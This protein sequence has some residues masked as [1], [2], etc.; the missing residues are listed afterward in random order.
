MTHHHFWVRAATF[1][2]ALQIVL[3]SVVMRPGPVAAQD[4]ARDCAG[5]AE[6][7][8][9]VAG[10]KAQVEAAVNDPTVSYGTLN[11]APFQH[12]AEALGELD[13]PAAVRDAQDALVQG[14]AMLTQQ[15]ESSLATQQGMSGGQMPTF[16]MQSA[17]VA[18]L[19]Q[20]RGQLLG[21]YLGWTVA[22]VSCGVTDG[23]FIP[24]PEQGCTG[25]PDFLNAAE[26]AIGGFWDYW[27]QIADGTIDTSALPLGSGEILAGAAFDAALRL[28]TTPAPSPAIELQVATVRYMGALSD[29]Y[30]LNLLGAMGVYY[31]LGQQAISQITAQHDQQQQ[32]TASQ[33][34]QIQQ[35]W[36]QL[37]TKCNAQAVFPRP[38]QR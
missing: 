31:G 12:A 34:E 36:D 27:Q 8:A 22:G 23:T 15:V 20:A 9:G 37:A 18:L 10:I 16:D 5:V 21:G 38:V 17:G 30:S 1:G 13:A 7:Y 19:S 35:D 33:A 25:V 29:L 28:A 14:Y 11:P 26:S 32:L 3:L 24:A 4:T 6:W 2:L